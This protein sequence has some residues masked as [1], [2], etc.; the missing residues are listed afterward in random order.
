MVQRAHLHIY[1]VITWQ[2]LFHGIVFSMMV[3][4][5]LAVEKAELIWGK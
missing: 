5:F 2:I 3:L 1:T 4:I